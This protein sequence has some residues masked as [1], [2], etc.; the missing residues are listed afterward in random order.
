MRRNA[1][2]EAYCHTAAE[3]CQEVE[4]GD[5]DEV[6]ASIGVAAADEKPFAEI[7][8]NVDGETVCYVEAATIE[9]VKA[10]LLEAEIT[11][12]P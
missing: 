11:I 6:Y 8:D 9:E 10:I 1:F 2:N 7:L 5:F 4:N 12:A 3:V